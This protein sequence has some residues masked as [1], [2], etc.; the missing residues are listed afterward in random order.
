MGRTG[1]PDEI[2]KVALSLASGDCSFVT[3]I[4]LFV[5]GPRGQI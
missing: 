1:D 4:E 5:D 2:A 3:G